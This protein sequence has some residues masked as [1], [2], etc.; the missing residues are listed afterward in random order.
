MAVLNSSI[1]TVV[2]AITTAQ[3]ELAVVRAG[4]ITGIVTKMF[5]DLEAEAVSQTEFNAQI[6]GKN[7]APKGMA[8]R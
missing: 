8:V 6:A 4:V 2:A 3:P 1:A 7:N 5:N